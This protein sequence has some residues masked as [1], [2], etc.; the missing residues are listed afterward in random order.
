M[1][2][3]KNILGLHYKSKNAIT[4]ELSSC[5]LEHLS[6]RNE[7]LGSHKNVNMIIHSTLI[8]SSPKLEIIQIPFTG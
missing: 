6:Q 4:I 7:D 8:H 1:A 3:L 2:I 5:T